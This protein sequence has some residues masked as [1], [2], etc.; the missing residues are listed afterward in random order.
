MSDT[1]PQRER[2]LVV[3]D[4]QAIRALLA[5]YLAQRGFETITAGDG[6]QA[7]EFLRQ[8][9]FNLVLSDVRMPGMDGFTLLGEISR[10]HPDIGVVM[11]TGCEDIS[12][13]VR[14]MKSGALDYILK[15]FKLAEVESGVRQALERQRE[16]LRK[17]EHVKRLE[18]TVQQQSVELR[19]M[20]E[21]LHE[22]SEVTLEALVAALDARER[23]THAHSLRV[24][25][26]TIHMAVELGVSGDDLEVLRRGAMLHDIGKIGISDTILLKPSALDAREW[27]EMRKHPLIG[28]WILKGIES[29]QSASDIVLSHHERF[30]GQGYPRELK[31][32]EIPLGARI[33]MV[34]DSMDAITSDRPYHAGKSYE[35]AQ[36][37]IERNSGTQFDP[38]VV[39]QFLLTPLDV[40][41]EIRK[42][43]LAERPPQLPEISPLVLT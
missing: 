8:D 25:E 2:I 15:P 42:R 12:L 6:G 4:E 40:W 27:I 13:A 35:E 23:E 36:R 30:D 1:P 41:E 5:G 21:H 29:L 17:A 32:D 22:A 34:A 24:S 7:L 11:L 33:F 26:Y 20:L 31:A 28:Y 19:R 18:I 3:D 16:I 39:D 9:N 14:A 10:R 38:D 37:E 43:T